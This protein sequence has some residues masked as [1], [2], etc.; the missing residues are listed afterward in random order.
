M[1]VHSLWQGILAAAVAGLIIVSTPKAGVRLRYG[2]L[3]L[4]I[5]LFVLGCGFTFFRQ[6]D[7]QPLGVSFNSPTAINSI[8]TTPKNGGLTELPYK[9]EMSFI[10][11]GVEFLNTHIFWIFLIWAGC[12]VFKSTRFV[13][14]LRHLHRLRHQQIHQPAERWQTELARLSNSL[15]IRSIVRLLESERV[16]VPVTIGHF[17]TLILVPVGLLTALSPEQAETV[18]LHELAHIRRKD[19][20]VNL[21]QCLVETV[22]FFNPALLW[23][24]ALIREEREACCDDLVMNLA[25]NRKSYLEVL[26]LFQEIQLD[27]LPFAMGLTNRRTHLLNRVKRMLSKE[28]QPLTSLEKVLLVLA[29]AGMTA[30]TFVPKPDTEKTKSPTVLRKPVPHDKPVVQH[31]KPAQ[32]V[33]TKPRSV[34]SKKPVANELKPVTTLASDTISFEGISFSRLRFDPSDAENVSH[35]TITATDGNGK[36][37]AITKQDGTVTG[38]AIDDQP[39]AAKELPRY[40]DLFRRVDRFFEERLEKKRNMIAQGLAKGRAEY[41]QSQAEMKRAMAAK[42]ANREKGKD[43]FA[44]KEKPVFSEKNEF[45]FPEKKTDLFVGKDENRSAEKKADWFSKK[46]ASQFP[47]KNDNAF[48]KKHSNQSSE[49]NTG[50]FSE[51]DN[52]RQLEQGSN[53]PNPPVSLKQKR[54]FDQASI[55][56]DVDRV[57]GVMAD[58]VQ[59][60][61]TASTTAIE[62]FGL[63]DSELI[64]NGKKQSAELHEKLRKK[65]GVR[66]NSGLYYGPVQM[67]GSGFFLDHQDVSRLSK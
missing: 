55:Q 59:E 18:L 35:V 4:V 7:S 8:V 30:F 9:P 10:Q 61:V 12:F 16:N 34:V 56:P 28:N 53:G 57:Y 1:L 41:D 46:N 26:V 21:M 62:W 49:K 66:P 42:Q 31:P 47:E 58:L 38:L 67:S 60:G 48:W 22:F 65:Y 44:G 6:F 33:V 37:Y 40:T 45:S 43:G 52:F 13:A 51:K 32:A 50:Q 15:E 19:Y 29:I 17:K 39:V 63:S 64:V 24:S 23:I 11:T 36:K 25:E 3:V 2:L 14:G 20:F 54:E 27:S 5:A